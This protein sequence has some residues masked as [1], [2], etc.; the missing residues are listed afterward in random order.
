[1]NQLKIIK[2]IQAFD[3]EVFEQLLNGALQTGWVPL[4]QTFQQQMSSFV[5]LVEKPFDI[6]H[7]EI[8]NG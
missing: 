3:R 4:Y 5:I 8:Q 6:N 1:M 7:K 2:I